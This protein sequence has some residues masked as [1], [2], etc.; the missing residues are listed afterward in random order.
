M[1]KPPL[2]VGNGPYHFVGAGFPLD[3]P[4][5]RG[6]GVFGLMAFGGQGSKQ[7][8]KQ[9]GFGVTH[10]LSCS[11]RFILVN[12]KFLGLFLA[13]PLDWKRGRE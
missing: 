3:Q 11:G 8:T 4:A 2:E 7:E 6:A 5:K 9:L 13:N 12:T 10:S 1:E